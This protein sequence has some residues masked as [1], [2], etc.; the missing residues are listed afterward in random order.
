MTTDKRILG[1]LLCAA[2]AVA[3]AC[4]ADG[5]MTSSTNASNSKASIVLTIAMAAPLVASLL[6]AKARLEV[7][8]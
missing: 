8:R 6:P 5:M 3:A 7:T 2:I 4:S 1:T